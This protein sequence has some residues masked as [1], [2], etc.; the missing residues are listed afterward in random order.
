MPVPSSDTEVSAAGSRVVPSSSVQWS[1][2]VYGCSGQDR[3]GPG[4]SPESSLELSGCPDGPCP[5][6]CAAKAQDLSPK[7]YTTCRALGR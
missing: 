1:S 7:P 6:E 5:E 4:L 2:W 3:G